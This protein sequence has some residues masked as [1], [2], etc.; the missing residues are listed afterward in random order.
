MRIRFDFEAECPLFGR[1]ITAT[2]SLDLLARVVPD[3]RRVVSTISMGIREI[4]KDMYLIFVRIRV[5][6]L[7]SLI[8]PQL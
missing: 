5:R 3:P 1:D 6:T 4:V 7:D 8:H 2:Q